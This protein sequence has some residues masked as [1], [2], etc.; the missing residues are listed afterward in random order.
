MLPSTDL[1]DDMAI[2]QHLPPQ[3]TP[4]PF[5]TLWYDYNNFVRELPC[6]VASMPLIYRMNPHIYQDLWCQYMWLVK[7]MKESPEWYLY[8]A[9]SA[10]VMALKDVEDFVYH[11][12]EVEMGLWMRGG[13]IEG[14]ADRNAREIEEEILEEER[15]AREDRMR[16]VREE[17]AQ[18]GLVD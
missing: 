14:W 15:V 9:A 1:D 18:A 11:E 2:H 16:K 13:P 12:F 6:P 10:E 7:Q 17:R 5:L 4:V 8:S 3:I